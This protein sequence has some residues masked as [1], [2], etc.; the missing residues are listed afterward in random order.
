[1]VVDRGA[2]ALDGCHGCTL[3][4]V[5]SDVVMPDG[6]TGIELA[7]HLARLYPRCRCC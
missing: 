7:R 5:F 3:R 6:M 4:L 1:V 2:K